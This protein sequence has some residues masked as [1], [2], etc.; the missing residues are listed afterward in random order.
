[1]EHLKANI[2]ALSLEFTPE[3][4]QKIENGYEFEIGFPHNLV[5]ELDGQY[6]FGATGH[7][8]HA[9]DGPLRLRCPPKR[10]QGAQGELTDPWR[11]PS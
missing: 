2:D 10:H 5:D 8:C 4:V 6:D 9:Y 11:A 3:D 7:P 1:M